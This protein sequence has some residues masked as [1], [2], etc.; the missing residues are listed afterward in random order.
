M[1]IL[2][3]FDGMSCGQIALNRA[4]I[5]YDKYFASEVDKYAIKV[6]QKNYPDT[7][8]IGDIRN[9]K[10][11]DLPKIDL[12]I[13]GSPCQGFSLAGKQ[14]NFDDPRSALFFEYVRLL[15]ELRKINPEIKFLLE[16][17]NMKNEYLRIISEYLGIFS[18][19]INS[20]LVSAQ[21]RARWYW[22]N[23]R[24][25]KIGLFEEL[26]TDIPQPEDKGILLKDILQPESEIDEKYYLRNVE[27][28]KAI[29]NHKSKVWRTGNKMGN[30]D[31]PNNKNKK[32]KCLTTI[33][34]PGDRSVN[35]IGVL[36][37]NGVFKETVKS[38]CLDANYFKGIDN[39]Q[40][41]TGILYKNRFRRLTPVEC[42][43]LQTVPDNYTDCV[44]DTQRYKMLGNGWTVDIIA[45]IFKYL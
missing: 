9:I 2:S 14:L 23:I 45:H 27:I 30:M 11:K 39:H 33:H 12:I 29:D 4:G 34:I 32:S 44:S 13:G 38:N 6:T 19:R 5:K 8:Q 7:I 1:N 18:V 20:N 35:H 28:I 41:R 21:N 16:N 26:Y 10:A 15:N 36:N 17:V 25:K 42:E 43:R 3:L 40:Q 22:S 37:N 24:T 31:F